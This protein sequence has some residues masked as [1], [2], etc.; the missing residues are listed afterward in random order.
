[1]VKLG[2]SILVCY[3]LHIKMSAI[4]PMVSV[5]VQRSKFGLIFK[6]VQVHG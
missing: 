6:R 1:M 2:Y 3:D 4:E 5:R